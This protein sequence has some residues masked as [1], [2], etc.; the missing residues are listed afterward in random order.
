[1][2]VYV[3]MYVYHLC[4]E[5]GLAVVCVCAYVFMYVC[6]YTY[7]FM[8]LC[9]GLC[10]AQKY[11]CVCACV[12]ASMYVCMYVFMHLCAVFGTGVFVCV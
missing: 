9:A 4:A 12:C 1:M 8:H 5:L 11:V 3:C 2:C 7:V 10:L 6:M